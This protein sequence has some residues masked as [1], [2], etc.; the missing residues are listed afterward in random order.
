MD[1]FDEELIVQPEPQEPENGQ[2][3]PDVYKKWFRTKDRSGFL[4][5]RPWTEKNKLS[6]DIGEVSP[7]EGRVQ[8][9]TLVWTDLLG[10]ATYLRAIAA[11][12]AAVIY[13]ASPRTGVPTPEGY[14]S[15]GGGN[16]DGK[17]VSRILKVHHWQQGRGDDAQYDPT[18]FVWKAGHFE[19]RTAGQGAFIPDM[20][21]PIS[22]NLIRVSRA[23]M[24]EMAYRIDLLLNGAVANNPH[25]FGDIKK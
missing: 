10:L 24:A 8:S 21:K 2:Q 3:T 15:Y 16:V 14:V 9:H 13:P 22:Q 17:P 19:A 4:S 20:T 18:S 11:N 25:Y 12:T 7:K 23:E 6:V 1:I 5:M